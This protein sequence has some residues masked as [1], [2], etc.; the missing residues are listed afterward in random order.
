LRTRFWGEYFGLR[1]KNITEGQ[2]RFIM[3]N[4]DSVLFSK[5]YYNH[6]IEEED[7]G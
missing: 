7:M 1:E 2:R 3:R 5:H 4:F 6:K